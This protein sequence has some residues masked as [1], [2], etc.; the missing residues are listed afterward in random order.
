MNLH[1]AKVALEI[2]QGKTVVCL[3]PLFGNSDG[4]CLRATTR[5]KIEGHVL[6]VIVS[7]LDRLLTGIV[8]LFDGLLTGIVSLR[9]GLH[10]GIVSMHDELNDGTVGILEAKD[11]IAHVSEIS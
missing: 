5:F 7:L 6:T 10:T 3:A 4:R 9:D 2:A 8:S 11:V 1:H